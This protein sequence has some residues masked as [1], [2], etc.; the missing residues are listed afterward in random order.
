M[1]EFDPDAFL[2]REDKKKSRGGFDPDAFL[3]K[4]EPETALQTFGRSAASLADSAL[5]A[6]TGTFDYAAYN[7]A[8]AAGRSPEQ[9]TAE[10][11]SPKDVIGRATGVA[12]TRG[13]ENAPIRAIGSRVG[14]IINENIVAPVAERT[15]LP[16]GDVAS[17][18]GSLSIGAG[19]VASRTVGAVKPVVKGAVDVG[20]ST[21]Q[22]F[23]NQ[24]A[25]PGEVP[26]PGQMPSSLQ[27]LGETYI[28]AETL[29]QWRSGKIS[30]AQATD[31]AVPTT[32]SQSPLP[33]DAVKR[34]R[35]Q[36]PYAGEGVKAYGEMLGRGY[37]DPAVLGSE[38]AADYFLAG[39]P[40]VAK[41]GV[42]GYQGY[43]GIQA[44]KELEKS[45]FTRMTP[46]EMQALNTGDNIYGYQAPTTN[47]SFTPPT[48]PAVPPKGPAQANA[49][50]L[51]ITPPM[52]AAESGFSQQ[53]AS[54]SKGSDVPRL[55]YNPTMYASETGI[56]GKTPQA[57]EQAVFEQKYPPVNVG[58]AVPEIMPA[59][60]TEI[61]RAIEQPP[62]PKSAP[63]AVTTGP[64]VPEAPV[65]TPT[66]NIEYGKIP[67]DGTAYY[68]HYIKG[69][70][71][72]REQQY[73][74]GTLAETL[75]NKIQTEGPRSLTAKEIEDW[76]R[77]DYSMGSMPTF[78]PAKATKKTP[79]PTTKEELIANASNQL[80][81]TIVR[82]YEQVQ[83]TP[84]KGRP[85]LVGK[86]VEEAKAFDAKRMQ[87][88]ENKRIA[89]QLKE[90]AEKEA[91]Q[92]ATSAK[93]TRTSKPKNVLEMK[94]KSQSKIPAE[95]ESKELT[96]ALLSGKGK[97]KKGDKSFEMSIT[98]DETKR[99]QVRNPGGK[100][101][102]ELYLN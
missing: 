55:T 20:K 67:V 102:D 49:Q 59:A 57:V 97:W 93:K 9:A 96:A 56:V 60:V 99:L 70:L 40:T 85:E 62:I 24:I 23:T 76:H 19:P 64:A 90:D 83:S 65:N 10:T 86:T 68:E 54:M 101:I 4:T 63:P 39:V 72:P 42:K 12:G 48:G 7:L 30:T 16:E 89:D 5:N 27:P 79:N 11:T 77:Y 33:Q 46:Q 37:R 25:K 53:L 71:T 81:N 61:P 73:A 15:G 8:R 2:A 95:Y 31:A 26:A 29:Q 92:L 80:A 41:L 75:Y 34:L 6:L 88:A 100:V 50:A 91:K 3:K 66:M 58:P 38:L 17:M 22:G 45:G 51:G 21:Y 36:V 44:A 28:P 52:T 43:K 35:G 1:A 47:Y 98:P 32:G 13:Y 84:F 94:I 14:D 69:G 87:D 74:P 18:L 82:N 78:T